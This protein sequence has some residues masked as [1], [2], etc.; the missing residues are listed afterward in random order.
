MGRLDGKVALVTGGARGQGAAECSLFAAEGA[1]VLIGDIRVE[2]AKQTEAEI[3]SQ[4]GEVTFVRMDV[5]KAGD[6]ASTIELAESKYGKLDILVNNAAQVRRFGI[7]DTTE[8]DWDAVMAVNAKGTFLGTKAAIPAMRRAGGGSIIN[9]SSI[10]GM[11]AHR[12]SLAAYSSSKGAIRIFS[13]VTAV[14]HAKDGIRCNSI[15]PGRIDTERDQQTAAEL[16]YNEHR[17]KG[18]PLVRLGVP[19]DVAYGALYLA[20]DESAWV[21]GIE[22]VIDGGLTAYFGTLPD[23]IDA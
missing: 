15:H 11:F 16:A 20:S 4:G 22:M 18:I 19:E 14:L 13:K 21:T 9:I 10:A 5:S 7:E 2:R 17:K 8:E 6:W 1:K 12:G 23:P 3:K